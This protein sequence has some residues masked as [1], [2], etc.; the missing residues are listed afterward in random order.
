M[1]ERQFKGIWIP[2]EVLELDI[3]MTCKMLWG[4]I[5]SFS[6]RDGA[7]YFKSNERIAGSATAPRP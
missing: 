6:N 3:P 1:S 2:V 4:D 7:S 5:H